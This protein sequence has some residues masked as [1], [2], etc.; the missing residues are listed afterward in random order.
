MRVQ[1]NRAK[2]E[3]QAAGQIE[4]ERQEQSVVK[5]KT[6]QKVVEAQVLSERTHS[7]LSCACTRSSSTGVRC[8]QCT[9][10][11]AQSA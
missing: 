1:V 2:A 11:H 5:E 4:K 6:Q 3:A 9:G 8:T 7:T 10:V